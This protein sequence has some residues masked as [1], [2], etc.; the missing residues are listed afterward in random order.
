MP[1]FTQISDKHVII[2]FPV[3]QQPDNISCGP[4]SALMVLKHYKIDVTLDEVKAHSKTKWF[5]IQG[6]IYGMTA[7]D[8]LKYS[9]NQFGIKSKLTRGNL[10]YLKI[11]LF[12]NKPTIILLRSGNKFWHYVVA[13]GY[14]QKEIIIA[15]PADAKIKFIKN[16]DFL[17]A[18]KFD[19]DLE[20]NELDFDIYR[21]LIKFADINSML[22]I[23]PN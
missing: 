1:D 3:L 10:K 14:N 19:G 16:N 8:Y 9:L 4:T 21:Q 17:S 22:M 15:D 6:K 23:I 20:G 2:D 12:K 5:E 11:Q 18:W 13:I 7:P